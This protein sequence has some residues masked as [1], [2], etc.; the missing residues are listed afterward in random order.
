[1]QTL[2]LPRPKNFSADKL[3]SA[4]TEGAE[5]ELALT[6][7]PGLVDRLNSGSHPDLSFAIMSR[8]VELLQL[9]FEEL[10]ITVQSGGGIDEIRRTALR[11][12]TRMLDECGTNTHRGY[13]FL[14]G[15]LLAGVLRCGELRGGMR[16]TASEL[17][18][19]SPKGT[20]GSSV[21]KKYKVGGIVGECLNGLPALFEDALPAY[22]SKLP[23]GHETAAFYTMSRLMQRVEDTTTL[24]RCA[25]SGLARL[26]ADGAELENLISAGADFYSFLHTLNDEYTSVN[27]TMGGV[28]DMLALTFAVHSISCYC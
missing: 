1:M 27:M 9:Y 17:L 14:G 4:L 3:V 11:A 24:H 10:A 19:N 8:S 21:R 6:P 13:I 23:L 5:K 7:K 20:N 26:K 28:A 15:V 18:E 22:I 12:E 2:L 25:E 16:M